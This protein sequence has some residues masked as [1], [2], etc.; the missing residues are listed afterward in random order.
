MWRVRN[1]GITVLPATNTQTECF[2]GEDLGA[3]TIQG[4]VQWVQMHP[5]GGEQHFLDVICR[6]KL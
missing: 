1:N 4:G 2:R 5:Q 3:A 6:G